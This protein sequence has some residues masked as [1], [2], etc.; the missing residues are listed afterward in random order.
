[1]RHCAAPLR[2]CVL[3]YLF[4]ADTPSQCKEISVEELAHIQRSIGSTA[5]S[6]KAVRVNVSAYLRDRGSDSGEGG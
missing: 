1:M 3:W 6:A 4:S 5:T 2:R